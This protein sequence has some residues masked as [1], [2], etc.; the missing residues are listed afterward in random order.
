MSYN[1]GAPPS[2]TVTSTPI[3]LLSVGQLEDFK[4]HIYL[5]KALARIV[6][7]FPNLRLVIVTHNARLLSDY[8]LFC[9]ENSLQ[10]H[11]RFEDSKATD[12]LISYYSACDIFVQPSIVDNFPITILEAMAS[13]RPI[14]AS[15]VGSVPEQLAGGSGI[16]S[17]PGDVEELGRILGGLI[18]NTQLRTLLGNQ[19]RHRVETLYTDDLVSKKHL[20][21][22]QQAI[23]CFSSE[24]TRISMPQILA[25]AFM[26][27]Y[28]RRNYI[29]RHLRRPAV[30]R[31]DGT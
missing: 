14:V 29:G 2:Y 31:G 17:P 7:R 25:R 11:V 6:P 23:R 22:Y 28:K 27:V 18:E 4:G 16:L 5:L 1:K 9:E 8:Q 24:G 3:S 10:H 15:S 19:A 26:A 21:A 12:E 13:S 20:V 30:V